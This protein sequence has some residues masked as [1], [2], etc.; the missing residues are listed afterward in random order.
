MENFI[1]EKEE[2][3]DEVVGTLKR[4]Y[5]SEIRFENVLKRSF[6]GRWKVKVVWENTKRIFWANKFKY[7]KKIFNNRKIS[8]NKKKWA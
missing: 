4:V 8:N 5:L 2:K 7:K 1:I 3:N 6:K